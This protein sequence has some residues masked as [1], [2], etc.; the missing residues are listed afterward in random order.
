M[1]E[2]VELTR[3]Q[4]FAIFTKWRNEAK[5]GGWEDGSPEMDTNTFI[6]YANDIAN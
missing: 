1:E 4:I 5:E 6:G 2:T 3:S